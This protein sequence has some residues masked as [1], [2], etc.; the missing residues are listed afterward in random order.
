[1][2]ITGCSVVPVVPA[3]CSCLFS[4]NRR[5]VVGFASSTDSSCPSASSSLTGA[6]QGTLVVK[7]ESSDANVVLQT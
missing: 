4:V 2:A 3:S 6:I 5:R 7:E 1:M